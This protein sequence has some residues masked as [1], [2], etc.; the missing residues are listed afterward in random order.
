M[1][2]DFVT[3]CL[4]YINGNLR[5]VFFAD[6][7]DGVNSRT[8]YKGG[9]G[10]LTAV[11]DFG[12]TLCGTQDFLGTYM[13]ERRFS[14]F[15]GCFELNDLG[16]WQV[17]YGDG[18]P[19]DWETVALTLLQDISIIF[20]DGEIE[21]KGSLYA[22]E[23]IYVTGSDKRSTVYMRTENGRTGYLMIKNIKHK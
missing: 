21:Q 8:Y 18:I 19:G 6:A 2:Y 17:V 22:D 3:F 9:Y 7:A 15:Q 23:K 11:D 4:N 5:P 16:I 1:S 14:L 20:N 12:I 10:K 13:T